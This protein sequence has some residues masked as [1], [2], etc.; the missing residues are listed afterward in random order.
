MCSSKV[1]SSWLELENETVV[2]ENAAY[3]MIGFSSST[4]TEWMMLRRVRHWCVRCF[5]RA[6]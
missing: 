3:S 4:A 2:G 5:N 1:L 6:V